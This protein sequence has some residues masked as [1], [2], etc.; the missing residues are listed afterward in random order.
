MYTKWH[1]STRDISVG[2]IIAPHEDGWFQPN[3]PLAELF[4]PSVVRKVLLESPM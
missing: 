4:R 1:K 3:G 2:N